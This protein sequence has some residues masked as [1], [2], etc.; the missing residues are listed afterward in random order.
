MHKTLWENQYKEVSESECNIVHEILFQINSTDVPPNVI[1]K[2]NDDENK[3]PS[4][5]VK[6]TIYF[7]IFECGRNLLDQL[8]VTY[9]QR[10]WHHQYKRY[11]INY[12]QHERDTMI[13]WQKDLSIRTSEVTEL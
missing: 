4:V 8:D 5:I 10:S 9:Q 2:L 7:N 11:N 12:L 3:E 13:N 6:G 1:T